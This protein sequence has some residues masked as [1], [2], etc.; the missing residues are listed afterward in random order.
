MF[1]LCFCLQTTSVL[2]PLDQE[3]IATVKAHYHATVFRQ[4]RHA[5]ESND[6]LRQ[7]LA[8][9]SNAD[10]DNDIDKPM[11]EEE[12]EDPSLSTQHVT[13]HQFWW[14]FT[15]KDAVDNLIQT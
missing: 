8:E 3:V 4:L 12:E 14:K 1:R 5:T 2:Q 6:E 10:G 15:V 9:D 7:I 13:V 11:E